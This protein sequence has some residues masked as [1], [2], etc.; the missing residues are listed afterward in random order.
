ME[1]VIKFTAVS[2]RICCL[3]M[4]GVGNNI[5]NIICVRAPTEDKEE[6][7]NSNFMLIWTSE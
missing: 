1:K 6:E 2:E 5:T 4:R 7:K 3:Q